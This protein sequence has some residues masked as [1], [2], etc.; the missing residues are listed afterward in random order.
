MIEL[1]NVEIKDYIINAN[2]DEFSN[3][4]LNSKV[5]KAIFKG[6]PIY[7]LGKSSVELL[8]IILNIEEEYEFIFGTP[9]PEYWVGYVYA[10][11]SWY[12][13][14]SYDELFK[15]IKPSELIMYYFPYHE[16]D[17]TRTLDIFNKRLNLKSKLR[18]LREK[19]N[20]SQSD[21]SVISDVPIRTIRSYEQNTNDIAIA[22][23]ETLYKLSNALDCKIEDLL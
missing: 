22:S 3:M 20:Y 15:A 6:D 17:I 4:F 1:R 7:G 12:L 13:N 14:V 9:T 18:T 10:F 2:I 21:L 19:K 11:A 8:E 16:M 23:G 5:S